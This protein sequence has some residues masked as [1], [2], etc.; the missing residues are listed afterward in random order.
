MSDTLLRN[1]LGANAAFSAISGLALPIAAEP[2]EAM[3]GP[4]ASQAVLT[5]LGF[6]L[7]AFAAILWYCR[8]EPRLTRA[9]GTIALLLDDLWVIGSLVLLL[10]F[11][12]LFTPFGRVLIGAVA[13][14]V[15][16]F[17]VLEFVGLRRLAGSRPIGARH[18]FGRLSA[19]EAA[20]ERGVEC[21]H[22]GDEFEQ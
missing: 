3:L 21:N 5:A 2:L 22:A 15:A 7:L 1:A 16:V 10:G 4:G 14:V 19:M 20:R 12:E 11:P 17:A 6:A 13:V 18:D 8:R 9:V